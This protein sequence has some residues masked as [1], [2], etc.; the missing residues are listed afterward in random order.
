MKVSVLIG[1][2]DRINVLTRCLHSVLAQDYPALE[3][4]VLDDASSQ[5]RLADLLRAEFTD[6][7]LCC[8]RVD[9]SL[10]VAGGRNRLLAEAAG[11]IFCFID[12]DAVFQT[13]DAVSQAVS[14]FEAHPSLGI[15]AAKVIDH[16]SDGR[17]RLYLPFTQRQ[18]K[19]EPR[20][21][22]ESRR[23]SYYLGTCH[24]IRRKVIDVCGGYLSNTK[25]GEEELDL[26]YRA[27]EAGFEL[28]YVPQVSIDHFPQPSVVSQPGQRRQMEL[29]YHTRNRFYL[30]YKYLPWRYVPVY[31]AIWLGVYGARALRQRAGREFFAGIGD[32]LR[33]LNSLQRTPL[34]RRA[35]AYLQHNFGRL[36][37]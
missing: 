23:V 25:F 7:R 4:I 14:A 34:S 9:E 6:P 33:Q 2:R 16:Y 13:T 18:M 22:S 5:Y 15:I 28:L 19:N 8:L 29:Y 20:L 31:L 30:A 24:A 12:D 36:W 10:G 27:I 17:I 21:M 37:Y 11:D 26:S 1:T 35:V 3:V 32:G